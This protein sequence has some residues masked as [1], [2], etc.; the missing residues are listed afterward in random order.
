M[1]NSELD[2]H[3]DRGRHYLLLEED[4]YNIHAIDRSFKLGMRLQAHD[5]KEAR[6]C[7]YLLAG[8]VAVPIALLCFI[9]WVVSMI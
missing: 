6:L 5:K 9:N 3:A 8:A 2:Y 1:K 4:G 7:Y